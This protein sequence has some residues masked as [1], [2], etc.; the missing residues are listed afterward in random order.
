VER[1]QQGLPAVVTCDAER[2]TIELAGDGGTN[3]SFAFDAVY[4][5]RSFFVLF[6]IETNLSLFLL[7]FPF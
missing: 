5:G 6:F 1:D 2:A 7:V 4:D 3:R